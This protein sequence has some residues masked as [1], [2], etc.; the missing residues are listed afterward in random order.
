MTPPAKNDPK[1]DPSLIDWEALDEALD[2]VAELEPS[3]RRLVTEISDPRVLLAIDL[4][5]YGGRSVA[6]IAERLNSQHFEVEALLEEGKEELLARVRAEVQSKALLSEMDKEWVDTLMRTAGHVHSAF[7]SMQSE[8]VVDEAD[9]KVLKAAL[10]EEPAVSQV[11]FEDT[12]LA[13]WIEKTADTIESGLVMIVDALE[14]ELGFQLEKS[15]L[16]N[17]SSSG[18]SNYDLGEMPSRGLRFTY[19]DYESGME[20]A[21]A[22]RLLA[23]QDKEDVREVRVE[24]EPQSPELESVVLRYG[25]REERFPFSRDGIATISVGA[26]ERASSHDK[27]GFAL[28]SVE[29]QSADEDTLSAGE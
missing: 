13:V 28:P 3:L 25:D 14:K 21:V 2:E 9:L 11:P 19:L 7:S 29:E 12:K 26:I 27:W 18:G 8:P 20:E 10:D 22:F 5:Y 16:P 24:L 1:D 6:E 23:S 15:G 4:H 17:R